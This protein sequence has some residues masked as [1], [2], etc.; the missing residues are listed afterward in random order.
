VSKCFLYHAGAAI[1]VAVLVS[2]VLGGGTVRQHWLFVDLLDSEWADLAASARRLTVADGTLLFRRGDPTPGLHLVEEGAIK[3]YTLTGSGDERII[4]IL[5]PGELC[6]EMGVVDGG[7]STAWGEAWGDSRLWVIPADLAQRLL[8]TNPQIAWQVS[9]LLV[10]KLRIASQQVD[11]AIFLRSRD[12]VIRQMLR[13]C[14]RYGQS[15]GEGLRISLR[16]TH[17]EI[18]RMAGTARET[19]SRTLGE[20]QDRSI[21]AFRE[22]F[23]LIRDPAALRALAEA[24]PHPF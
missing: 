17:E 16:M 5:G 10:A 7:A 22:R 4:D 14:D 3:I 1:G 15:D 13:L 9:R 11:E 20:L 6:G 8:R 2:T 24:E 21:L 18:A 19:V 12:R 23:M